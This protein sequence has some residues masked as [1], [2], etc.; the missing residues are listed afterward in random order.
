MTAATAS[1]QGSGSP[2]TS[3][4]TRR[5][6]HLARR[7][8]CPPS[9]SSAAAWT[10]NYWSMGVPG[11]CGPCVGDLLRPRPRARP[12]RAARRPSEDRLPRD[13]EPRLHAGRARRGQ[14]QGRLRRSSAP[15]PAQ[16]HRHRHG[17]SSGSPR[18]LQ[19]V[20]NDLRDRPG[21]PGHRR[22]PGAVRA[23][24]YGAT[25]PRTTCA[26]A[27]DRRPRPHASLMLIG[28]GVTPSNEGRGYVLR[29]LLRR[30]DPLG[31]AARR[32]RT[33][34]CPELL[35]RAGRGRDGD[36]SAGA[37]SPTAIGSSG[38]PCAEEEAFRPHPGRAG[39]AIFE[40]AAAEAKRPGRRRSC[41]ATRRLRSCTT[42]TA[43]PI[44]LTLEMAVRGRGWTVDAGRLPAADGRAA[45]TAA[46]A[47]ARSRKTGARR[48]R[49]T[50][51]VLARH[52]GT[53]SVPRLR[54]LATASGQRS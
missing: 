35:R 30:I 40:T 38:G 54:D 27:V 47:D 43:S 52:G 46:K 20:D 48:R 32:A 24:R 23:R 45:R 11:P 25:R 36:G 41:P 22:G 44:D 21:A 49:P 15:L 4:T 13:L 39:T 33:R 51:A 2:S 1:T 29:R 34:C 50:A 7:S 5:V 37:G 3:T 8:A 12:P 18:C 53:L 42:P 19:G 14:R 9:A 10:D 6:E 16:E 17:R 31:A 28:D 26:C